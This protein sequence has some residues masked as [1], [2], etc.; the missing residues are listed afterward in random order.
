MAR[1]L[2]L[3]KECYRCS[4]VCP[5]TKSK[6]NAEGQP[7]PSR[8]AT[9]KTTTNKQAAQ[10]M[11]IT[12][13]KSNAADNQQHTAIVAALRMAIK[14]HNF[15]RVGNRSFWEKLK[16][17]SQST[18]TD[19][20]QPTALGPS[21]RS[22]REPRQADRGESVDTRSSVPP[23]QLALGEVGGLEDGLAPNPI[24]L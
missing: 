5:L 14:F 3:R 9:R 13:T 6:G 12:A 15:L 18:A 19:N 23:S 20:Q 11:T 1:R 2:S 16:I 17:T 21:T 4:F 8:V 24:N 10:K 7:P 22:R